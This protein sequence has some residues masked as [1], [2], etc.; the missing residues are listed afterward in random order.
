M[1]VAID[2]GLLPTIDRIYESVE[3]PELWPETIYLIGES[4]GGRRGFWGMGAYGL[5]PGTDPELNKHWLR[6]GSHAYF[7]SRSDLRALDRDI[8][9]RE[10]IGVRL[11]R[12]YLPAF[13]PVAGTSISAPSRP[14]LRRLI[15]AL[16]EDGCVFSS[17]DLHCI[18][19]LTPHLDRALRLQMRLS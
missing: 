9:T 12:R 7:L 15:A 2:R 13:E 10:I 16:W 6:A 5:Y 18:R 1:D 17:D 14:A 8:D 3:R 19:V 4:I 11:A